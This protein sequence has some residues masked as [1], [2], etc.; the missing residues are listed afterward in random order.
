MHLYAGKHVLFITTK[1]LDYL[2]NTQEIAKLRESAASVDV[3][4]SSEKSY[5]RRLLHV[6]GKLSTMSLKQY[7]TIFVGFAPQL[8]LPLFGWRFRKKTVVIDF[9]I[10]V[11]DTM[12]QDRK[13]WKDGSMLAKFCHWIDRSTLRKADRIISDT[14]AHG[15]YFAKEFD[16]NR[17]RGI[18]AQTAPFFTRVRKKS[19]QNCKTN[20][21]SCISAVSCRCRGWTSSCR[22][23]SCSPMTHES[24][25]ISSG[26]LRKR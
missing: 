22:R 9:F 18:S 4:G 24:T 12:I 3:L 7:D 10:S 15:D 16:I 14:N 2:R 20:S 5:A 13:K 1:N 23:C 6:Y 26:Q 19:R 8:I 21:L 11:Y 25:L 17:A